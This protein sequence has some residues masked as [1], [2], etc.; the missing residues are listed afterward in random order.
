MHPYL[1]V[2]WKFAVHSYR[3]FLCIHHMFTRKQYEHV[4]RKHAYIN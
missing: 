1:G 4:T 2:G 3:V